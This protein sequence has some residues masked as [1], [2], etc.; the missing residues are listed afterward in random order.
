[1]RFAAEAGLHDWIADADFGIII[2]RYSEI[3]IPIFERVADSC[4][5]SA[6][7]FAPDR[8]PKWPRNCVEEA[9]LGAIRNAFDPAG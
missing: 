5:G 2:G 7:F 3:E 6:T 4:G 8:A 9:A 1:L